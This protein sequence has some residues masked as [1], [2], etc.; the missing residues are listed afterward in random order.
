MEYAHICNKSQSCIKGLYVR[1]VS[2]LLNLSCLLCYIIQFSPNS[3]VPMQ[4]LIN[5]M[6]GRL[7][8]IIFCALSLSNFGM[9][10]GA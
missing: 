10:K 2:R 9:L 4:N 7:R 5:R 6:C 3:I 1:K 8:M